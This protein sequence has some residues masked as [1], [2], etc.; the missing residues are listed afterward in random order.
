M[1]VLFLTFKLGFLFGWALRTHLYWS[2]HRRFL[3]QRRRK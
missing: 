1:L 3:Q 2:Q